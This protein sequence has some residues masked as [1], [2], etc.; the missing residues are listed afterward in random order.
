MAEVFEIEGISKN[1]S[2][3]SNLFFGSKLAR[4]RIF[5]VIIGTTKS[6]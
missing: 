6:R 3:G 4:K 2:E 1:L 5:K